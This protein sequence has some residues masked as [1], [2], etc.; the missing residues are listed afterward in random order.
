M[1]PSQQLRA[2]KALISKPENWTQDE[3]AKNS[4]GDGTDVNDDDAVCFC[5]LGAVQGGTQCRH[6]ISSDSNAGPIRD[7]GEDRQVR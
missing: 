1:K 4:D 7:D 2:A 6:A 5:A 3:Y